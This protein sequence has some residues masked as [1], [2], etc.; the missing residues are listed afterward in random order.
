MLLLKQRSD[1]HL[2]V[3]RCRPRGGWLDIL[4]L[5][6]SFVMR[7]QSSK[8]FNLLSLPSLPSSSFV[9][10]KSAK[11]CALQ[12]AQLNHAELQVGSTTMRNE[13]AESQSCK[14]MPFLS[15]AASVSNDSSSHSKRGQRHGA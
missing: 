9:K 5:D 12:C 1:C 8:P 11:I 13:A 14:Q 10:H 6:C 3:F 15:D 2:K 4:L 7:E